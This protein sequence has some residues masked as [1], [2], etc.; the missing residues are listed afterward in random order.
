MAIFCYVGNFEWECLTN[1]C[2]WLLKSHTEES[3]KLFVIQ[4]VHL[5]KI[6]VKFLSFHMQHSKKFFYYLFQR[7]KDQITHL[8]I[9]KFFIYLFRSVMITHCNF[10]YYPFSALD[11]PNYIITILPANY[12]RNS[13]SITKGKIIFF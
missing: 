2:C 5:K 9:M 4:S 6:V 8:F 1:K 11:I 3:Y 13:L 12:L 7:H 10:I